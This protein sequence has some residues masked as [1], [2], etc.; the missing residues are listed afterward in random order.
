[1]SLW[2]VRAGRNGEYEYKFLSEGKI[3]ITWDNLSHDLSKLKSKQEFYELQ[4]DI[5]IRRINLIG[6]EIG[7]VSYGPS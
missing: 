2:L 1:M 5:Y 6:L 3:Y 4:I 7:Q